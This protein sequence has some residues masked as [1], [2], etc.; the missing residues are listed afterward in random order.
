METSI[1]SRR[2]LSRWVRFACNIKP[3]A[4]GRLDETEPRCGSCLWKNPSHGK[5]L[6]AVVLI[7]QRCMWK[8]FHKQH[9]FSGTRSL[10]MPLDT[11]FRRQQS[12]C[13]D[14][15]SVGRIHSKTSSSNSS[16]LFQLNSVYSDHHQPWVFLP[17]PG[18]GRDGRECDAHLHHRRQ[19]AKALCPVRPGCTDQSFFVPILSLT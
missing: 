6:H 18:Q 9:H 3:S 17:V 1:S 5:R 14:V 11:G 13:L 16:C 10:S 12:T 8:L 19:P 4:G 15:F 7:L 2:P